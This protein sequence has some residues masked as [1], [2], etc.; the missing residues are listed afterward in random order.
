MREW[1]YSAKDS[2]IRHQIES[3][4]QL[5]TPSAIAPLKEPPVHPQQG[6][7]TGGAGEECLEEEKKSYS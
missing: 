1:R 5:H 7:W 2:E 3:N 6:V 4:G